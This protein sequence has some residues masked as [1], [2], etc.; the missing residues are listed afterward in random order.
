MNAG[1]LIFFALVGMVIC[2]KSRVPAGA[3]VFAVLALT[4]FIGTPAGSGLP[5]LLGDFL[6]AVSQS[7]EPF[8][9][10]SKGGGAG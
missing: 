10:T 7:A 6:G 2:A 3:V 8:T 9:A 1:V 5:A 4:L